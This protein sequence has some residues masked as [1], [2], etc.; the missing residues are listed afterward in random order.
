M[1]PQESVRLPVCQ[2]I[3]VTGP[4]DAKVGLR[5]LILRGKIRLD[6]ETTDYTTGGHALSFFPITG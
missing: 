6:Y 4:L 1:I 2:S 3:L 5:V